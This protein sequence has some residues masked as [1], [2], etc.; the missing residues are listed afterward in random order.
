MTTKSVCPVCYKE[1]EATIE[2]NG[3]VAMSKVCKEH[4]Y[5]CSTVE[6]DSTWYDL[7]K[8]TNSK[9]FYP[10][11]MVDVTGLCNL[12]CKYCYH[13]NSGGNR[14]VDD[15]LRD[16]DDNIDKAPILLT[17]GEPTLHPQ[18]FDILDGTKGIETWILTNGVKLSDKDYLEELT[19]HGVLYGNILSIGLSFHKESMGMDYLFLQLCRKLGYKVATTFW[20]IDDLKQIDEALVV[21]EG[22]QDVICSMRIK[23][24]SNLWHEEKAFNKIFTSDMVR[25]MKGKGA[26]L[27]FTYNVK[28]S[29]APM[30]YK[31]IRVMLISWYDKYNVDLNDIDCAPWYRAKDGSINNLVTTGILNERQNV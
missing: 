20:V 14:P 16:I 31:G 10:G 1:I 24:A 15:I 13:D 2:A 3:R 25:S 30:L 11:Y 4:G 12:Q 21:L 27:D 19:N 5:F 7:C 26:E 22:Y 18:L 29:Y 23:A 28:N 9:E 17:G 6:K 8:Q